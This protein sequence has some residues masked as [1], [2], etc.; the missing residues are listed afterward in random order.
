MHIKIE[1]NGNITI[2]REENEPKLYKESTFYRHLARTINQKYQTDM[3][4]KRMWKDGHMVDNNQ[5]YLVDRKREYGFFQDDWSLYEINQDYFNKN[6]PITL[7]YRNFSDKNTTKWE[8]ITK[9][10]KYRP[11][12]RPKP[13][14]NINQQTEI[15][16][17]I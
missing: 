12:T 17:Y 5:F 10:I 9:K 3:I 15:Q 16:T 14:Q 7:K 4:P 2:T 13:S 6:V 1:P 8:S 11:D